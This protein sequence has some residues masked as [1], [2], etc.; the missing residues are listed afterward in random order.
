MREWHGN[1]GVVETSVWL[2][3]VRWNPAS[4]LRVFCLP[5]AGGAAS[6]FAAWPETLPDDIEVAALQLPGRETRFREPPLRHFKAIV[7][8]AATALVPYFDRPYALF[9][10]S[11]G[12]MLAFE[13]AR[14]MRRRALPQPVQLLVSAH[15][16]PHKY[17]PGPPTYNLDDAA[18]VGELRRRN[19]TPAA[20]LDHPDLLPLM[21]PMLRADFEVCETYAYAPDAP[22]SCPISAY[23]ALDDGDVPPETIHAWWEQTTSRFEARFWTGGHFFFRTFEREL[24]Q[25]VTAELA[26]AA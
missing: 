20:V 17:R 10:H 9:G 22:L 1:A 15:V 6:M 23:G 11:M 3:H 26:N 21:L 5:H 24:L 13:L 7:D 14:E 2:P 12:A 4:R 16:A 8:R 19:G 18:F 25:H